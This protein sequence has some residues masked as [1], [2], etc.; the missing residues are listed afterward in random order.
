M[1]EISRV[2][3]K[4]IL[5]GCPDRNI[6]SLHAI[7]REQHT[8]AELAGIGIET[9]IHGQLV[10]AQVSAIAGD[11]EGIDLGVRLDPARQAG[12]EG[13]L[14][15]ILGEQ[16]E[17]R[18]EGQ[19]FEF[20]YGFALLGTAHAMSGPLGKFHRIGFMGIL[21][22]DEIPDTQAMQVNEQLP[23]RGDNIRDPRA[24]KGSGIAKTVGDIHAYG[25][26]LLW[27]RDNFSQGKGRYPC[28]PV[29]EIT[30]KLD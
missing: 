15:R 24:G 23:G 8:T 12:I 7:F 22:E 29:F 27:L 5:D 28:K 4:M 3:R 6:V 16:D 2:G 25:S 21:G 30:G 19:R 17:F 11:N 26:H 10:R 1:D 20:I 13:R 18:E 14:D 9:Q